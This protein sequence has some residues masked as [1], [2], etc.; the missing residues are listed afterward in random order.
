MSI[1]AA[2]IAVVA[3]GAWLV[4]LVSWVLAVKHRKPEISLS[5]LLFSGLRAF[6]PANFTEAGRAHQRR[7]LVAFVVFFVTAL[8]GAA[9]SAV[10]S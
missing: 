2:V 7:F 8:A 6:D 3:G 10:L 4:A 1:L 9:I 5:S